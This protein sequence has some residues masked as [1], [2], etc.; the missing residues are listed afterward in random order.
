[1]AAMLLKLSCS[2]I[3]EARTLAR[4]K[5]IRADMYPSLRFGIAVKG[6]FR[7]KLFMS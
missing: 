1:M 2:R 4:L 7:E 5:S 3:R 6:Y